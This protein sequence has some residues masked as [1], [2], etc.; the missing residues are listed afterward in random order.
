ML[1]GQNEV[2]YEDLPAGNYVFRV[3]I[4]G[5][6]DSEAHLAVSVGSFFSPTFWIVLI[7]V[8]VLI[9]YF[10]PK[11][12]RLFK[13]KILNNEML[14]LEKY[15]QQRQLSDA[16]KADEKYKNAKLDEKECKQICEKLKS[17]IETEKPY[18]KPDLKIVDLA[19]AIN[20]SS[21]SLSYI[22]NQ[23]LTKNYYDFINEYRIAEFK[24]L[25][26]DVNYSKYTLS[27]LAERSGFSSRASFFRS[28]KKLTGIT[29]NEYIKSIGRNIHEIDV[30]PTE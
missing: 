4:Q 19:L 13:N 9:W 5:D 2:T 10:G 26:L 7:L 11:Y 23:Y 17:F 1:S 22:F 21:H 18:T 8:A 16:S 12:L 29:P 20:C 28:F 6:K 27:A 25:I 24:R 15:K 30:D 3:R 14:T